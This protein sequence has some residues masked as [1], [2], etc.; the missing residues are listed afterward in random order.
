MTASLLGAVQFLTI[1]PIHR[2]TAPLGRSAVFFPLVGAAIGVA[3]A[4][5]FKTTGSPLLVLAFWALLTGGLHEDGFADVADAFRAGRPA[6]KIHTIL[7]D[8]RIGAHG[9]LALIF[10]T[11]IRWQALTDIGIDAV[12]GLAVAQALPRAALVLLAWI[13]PPAGTGLGFHFSQT[14]ST[15]IAIMAIGQGII[16]ALA[17]GWRLGAILVA[18][19]AAIVFLAARYFV[20]RIGG[21]TGDCLGATAYMVETFCLLVLTCQSCTL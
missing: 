17:C 21:I 16:F 19:S 20:R 15:P 9:A 4:I 7:K 18:G 5:V 2:E 10:S 11:L 1:I 6:E 13:A 3:G 8:S 12:P 14:L